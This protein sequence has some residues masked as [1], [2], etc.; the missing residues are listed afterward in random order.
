[1]V[2]VDETKTNFLLCEKIDSKGFNS[3]HIWST[4]RLLKLEMA[5]WNA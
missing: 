4:Y 5:E 1:M 2:N 3:R